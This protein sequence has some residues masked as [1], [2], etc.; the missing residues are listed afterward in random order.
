MKSRYYVTA[1]PVG[2]YD[3]DTR[4]ETRYPFSLVVSAR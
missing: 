1:M 4:D 3:P 2:P